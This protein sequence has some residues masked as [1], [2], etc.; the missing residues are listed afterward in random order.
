[1]ADQAITPI[2]LA[3]DTPSA[4][5]TPASLTAANDGLITAGKDNMVIV[6]I[7]G[8]AGSTVA[9]KAGDGML[10]SQG[11]ITVTLGANE[12]KCVRVQSARVK[13]LSGADKGKIRLDA[14][15]NVSAYALIVP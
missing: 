8:G 4:A 6:L 15:G 5:I 12:T 7:D 2:T 3:V 9:I 1:M 11:D 10:H 14:S 13:W